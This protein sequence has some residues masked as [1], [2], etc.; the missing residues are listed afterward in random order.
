MDGDEGARLLDGDEANEERAREAV[1]TSLTPQEVEELN[2]MVQNRY[3]CSE[4][5]ESIAPTVYGKALTL[6]LSPC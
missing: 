4:L 2:A 3:I 6:L 1:L 5:V